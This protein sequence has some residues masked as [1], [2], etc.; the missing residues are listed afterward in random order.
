MCA[1]KVLLT[2]V[3]EVGADRQGGAAEPTSPRFTVDVAVSRRR[4]TDALV[5]DELALSGTHAHT[6]V[7]PVGPA[8]LQ[9]RT[10]PVVEDLLVRVKEVRFTFLR[11]PQEAFPV[12]FV[13]NGDDSAPA[14]Y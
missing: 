6:T 5:A 9:G 11:R 13:E 1:P 12:C 4:K 8:K 3:P 7:R 10:G 2:L 14:S